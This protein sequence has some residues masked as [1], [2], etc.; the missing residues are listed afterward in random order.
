MAFQLIIVVSKLKWVDALTCSLTGIGTCEN[1]NE[2][3]TDGKN[4]LDNIFCPNNLR[5][6]SSCVAFMM[7]TNPTFIKVGH[8]L[9]KN[10]FIF[11]PHSLQASMSS[12]LKL[13]S[14]LKFNIKSGLIGFQS[15]CSILVHIN[16]N[17]SF[18]FL[19]LSTMPYAFS[20]TFWPPNWIW[21]LAN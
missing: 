13:T 7:M 9:K 17:V 10:V 5:P 20:H 21:E 19:R 2:C 11:I 1:K 4:F 8:N 3:R 18:G 6:S 16:S 14:L 12:G 15:V